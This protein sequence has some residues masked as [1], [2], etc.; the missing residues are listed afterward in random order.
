MDRFDRTENALHLPNLLEKINSHETINAVPL[1]AVLVQ[2]KVKHTTLQTRSLR[3]ANRGK[4]LPSQSFLP[5]FL[6]RTPA[7]SPVLRSFS[8]ESQR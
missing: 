7:T 1:H 8:F 5:F 3:S 4:N 2:A 6:Q